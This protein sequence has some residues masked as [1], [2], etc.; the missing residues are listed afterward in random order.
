MD[1]SEYE[2]TITA[3]GNLADISW[4]LIASEPVGADVTMIAEVV[5]QG[6]P[7]VYQGANGLITVQTARVRFLSGSKAVV[8]LEALSGQ[9]P[10]VIASKDIS[11][12][13]IT[14]NPG[15]AAVFGNPHYENRNVNNLYVA[16]ADFFNG[17]RGT[18]LTASIAVDT[19]SVAADVSDNLRVGYVQYFSA[20][21]EW[22]QYKENGTPA[23]RYLVSESTVPQPSSP[24]DNSIL[25]GNSVLGRPWYDALN[26]A[27]IKDVSKF[28]TTIE[29]TDTPPVEV[30]LSWSGDLSQNDAVHRVYRKTSFTTFVV[31]N[32]KSD[33]NGEG[34][35]YY[36]VAGFA[37]DILIDFTVTSVTPVT[38]AAGVVFKHDITGTFSANSGSFVRP[39][40]QN[41]WSSIDTISPISL[42]ITSLTDLQPQ[43][44]QSS[45]P[46]LTG[47]S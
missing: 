14:V 45:T 38:N 37:W 9:N 44:V 18:E 5:S 42:P 30:P 35:M 26:P 46:T 12:A 43:L 19:F 47:N 36:V 16:T 4:R 3:N 20:S 8:K 33:T 7:I 10:V 17:K 11:I 6:T 23:D 24:Q 39:G 31:V 41:V 27:A 21:E 25:D 29:M 28:G 13:K 2:Y 32:V 15:Q 34:G 40:N 22:V 1:A